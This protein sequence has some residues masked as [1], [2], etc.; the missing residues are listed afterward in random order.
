MKVLVTRDKVVLDEDIK[1]LSKNG[2]AVEIITDFEELKKR[3]QDFLNQIDVLVG[4]F[5]LGDLDISQYNN[6]KAVQTVSAGY[7]YL[8][9]SKIK[10]NDV[11]LMNA[12]GV[13]SVPIAEWVIGQI[14]L[15]YKKFLQFH[16]NQKKRFW[17]P[18]NSLSELTDKRVL[19]FGT[20]SIGGEIA[21][22][23]APFDCHVDGV[24]SNGRR[25]HGFQTCYAL[26]DVLS[27]VNQY[28]ILVFAL[29][30]NKYTQQYVDHRFLDKVNQSAILINIGR[31]DL[32]V[33][34]DLINH[35]KANVHTKAFLDVTPDEPLSQDSELWELENSF[36]TPHNSYSSEYY[37]K[38]LRDLIVYNLIN[39]KNNKET[40]NDISLL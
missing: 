19:I 6:L 31:G 24:N 38:R 20:G 3:H 40:K 37:M 30:S 2:I 35:L 33:E 28:D 26:N 32:M 11:K 39:I 7:D 34:T 25:I 5:E 23:L 17:S 15:E 27:I 21:K 29:P 18:T 16:E 10:E 36:I 1:Y 9:L 22:R 4:G 8:Q 12:S 14:L 13:Y